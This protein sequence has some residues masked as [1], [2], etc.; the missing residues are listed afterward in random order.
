MTHD[1]TPKQLAVETLVRGCVMAYAEGFKLRHESE[2]NNPNGVINMKIHNI[3]IEALGPEIRY[4]TALVRSLDSSLGNMLEKLAI[5]I[6]ELSFEVH[7]NISGFISEDQI[8]TIAA[9]LESYKSRRATPSLSDYRKLH[10]SVKGSPIIKQH[11]SDYYLIDRA[12]NKHYLIE[13]KIGGDLDNKKARSEKEAI[14]EQYTIL[15]NQ[16]SEDATVRT[17]FATAY[18]RFGE[19]QPWAQERVR[20]FFADEELLIGQDFW[21][22]VCQSD[23]G[24][25]WVLKAYRDSA[26]YIRLALDS[27]RNTYLGE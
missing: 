2:V 27:I 5:Q 4:Y 17:F 7:N 24:Y 12:A 18:N 22:F 8:S 9:I 16:L 20:Q 11:G 26:H 23:N 14:M 3:F 25:E 10:K 19:G 15:T 6:A 1:N 13:L 21:N